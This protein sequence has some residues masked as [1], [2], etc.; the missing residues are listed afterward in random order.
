MPEQLL[1]TPRKPEEVSELKAL[2]QMYYD[3][4]RFRLRGNNRVKALSRGASKSERLQLPVDSLQSIEDG[5]AKNILQ[6]VKDEPI[7]P[8]LSAQRGIGHILAAAIIASG[9]DPEIDK[10]S[11]WWRY[12]GV[13]I[14]DGKNQ[15][16]RRGEKRTYNGFLRRTL[17]VLVTSFL[18]SHDPSRDRSSFYAELY[19]RFREESIRNRPELSIA[20]PCK[21]CKQTG[22][23]KDK[24]S[25]VDKI[26]DWC[27]GKGESETMFHHH[28]RAMMLTQRVFL[29]HLQ[30]K[31]RS[32]LKLT[33]PRFPYI[34]EKE[35]GVHKYIEAPGP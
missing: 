31:W 26:C 15:R 29:T 4:Q 18:K 25:E 11:S 16:P 22:K 35:P 13:G 2:V 20:H 21:R 23:L 32:A 6:V 28:A 3:V 17:Y 8:W 14:V 1:T 5:I 33:R 24:I 9:L 19:Y 30:E 27:N 34:V 12:A 10:P 7:W